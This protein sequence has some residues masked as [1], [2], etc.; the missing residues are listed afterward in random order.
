MNSERISCILGAMTD[1][2][3]EHV[4]S[5]L[6]KEQNKRQTKIALSLEAPTITGNKIEDIKAF[7]DKHNVPLNVARL[8]VNSAYEKE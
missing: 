5:L 6:W 8:A 2:E 3:I 1:S 4:A 7:R